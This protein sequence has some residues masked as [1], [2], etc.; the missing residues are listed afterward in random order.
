MFEVVTRVLPDGAGFGESGAP[1]RPALPPTPDLKSGICN[2]KTMFYLHGGS[3][4]E[5]LLVISVAFFGNAEI[6]KNC[7]FPVCLFLYFEQ[8]RKG[9]EEEKTRLRG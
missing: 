9:R 2:A 6:V 7:G 5:N 1:E 3:I 8:A 4:F